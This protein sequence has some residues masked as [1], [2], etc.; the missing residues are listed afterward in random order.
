MAP[1]HTIYWRSYCV[2]ASLYLN[3]TM[4]DKRMT[5]IEGW[6]PVIAPN[7][8]EAQRLYQLAFPAD[9]IVHVG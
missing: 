8:Q 7:A 1:T 9:Q 6:T 3:P 4:K 5:W 2:G